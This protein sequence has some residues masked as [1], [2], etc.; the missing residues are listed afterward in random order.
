MESIDNR[1]LKARTVVYNYV[2]DVLEKTDERHKTFAL[3]EVYVVWFCKV[4]KNWKALVSTTLPDGM[5]YEVT[6]DG[7]LGYTYL[8]A[9]KK[10]HNVAIPDEEFQPE[11][12]DYPVIPI[13][14]DPLLSTYV[15]HP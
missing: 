4:L 2:K 11:L 6:Y 1:Q 10:F 7:E 15:E 5:Y 9:Y 13:K 8:D 3:D 14:P 12:K